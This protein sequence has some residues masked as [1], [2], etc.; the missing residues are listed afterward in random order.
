[1]DNS[2]VRYCTRKEALVEIDKKWGTPRSGES[3]YQLTPL[4]VENGIPCSV[5]EVRITRDHTTRL[6]KAIQRANQS[7]NHAGIGEMAGEHDRP[8]DH[9][10]AEKLHWPARRTCDNSA[11]LHGLIFNCTG[12]QQNYVKNSLIVFPRV[13]SSTK[14]LQP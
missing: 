3:T 14:N 11:N 1:M 6:E 4:P 13:I 10:I 9:N 5:S 7:F 12:R 2:A 8:G